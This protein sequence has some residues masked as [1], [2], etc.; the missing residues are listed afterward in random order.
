MKTFSKVWLGIGV[1]AIGFGLT[2]LII[3]SI[4]GYRRRDEVPTFTF[5]ENYTDVKAL[6]IEIDYGAVK[7]INGDEFSIHADNLYEEDFESFLTEDGTWVIRDTQEIRY[8]NGIFNLRLP[9]FGFFQ[10]NGDFVP[11]IVVTIP[12]DFRASNISINI[13]A[14]KL[15]A[16]TLRSEKG[17]FTVD[18]GR[19][20]IDEIVITDKSFYNV[21]AGDMTF[22]QMNARDITLECGVGNISINGVITGDNDITCDVGRV[23]LNLDGYRKDYSYDIEAD[24]GSVIIDNDTYHNIS[25]SRIISKGA[26]NL[27]KLECSI[28]NITVDFK[29]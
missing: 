21:G 18:A 19:L 22:K 4:Y 24:L 17:D 10:W 12:E 2:L 1:L 26:S 15:S 11:E 9:R 8:E 7:I 6:E 28:G 14:G 5:E 23:Y 25:D 16:E 29:E 13:S 20:E 27:L 3:A